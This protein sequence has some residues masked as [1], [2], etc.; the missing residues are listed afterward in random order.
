METSDDDSAVDDIVVDDDG[1]KRGSPDV[2][3]GGVNVP[4]SPKVSGICVCMASI[5]TMSTSRRRQFDLLPAVQLYTL[6]LSCLLPWRPSVGARSLGG[7]WWVWEFCFS[8]CVFDT[9][10]Q[11]PSILWYY[12]D[13]L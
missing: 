6:A 12:T 3:T 11:I 8:M 13:A 1:I 4:T 2:S 9:V 7:G 10:D 5:C